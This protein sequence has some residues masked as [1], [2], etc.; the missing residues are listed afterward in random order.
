MCW[1]SFG[2]LNLILNSVRKCGLKG[3]GGP[4]MPDMFFAQ[5]GRLYSPNNK[6]WCVGR[7]LA[8]IW[9]TNGLIGRLGR[10]ST[11]GISMWALLTEERQFIIVSAVSLQGR[12][13]QERATL[14]VYPLQANQ[15]Y[16]M[17]FFC[18]IRMRAL[19]NMT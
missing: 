8:L 3:A 14:V 1:S 4:K 2:S 6:K 13:W 19:F 16:G 12:F 15:A 9:G 7:P 18:S 11:Q 5:T 10:A 17:P